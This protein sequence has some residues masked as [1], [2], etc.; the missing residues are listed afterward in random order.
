MYVLR[1][2]YYRWKRISNIVKLYLNNNDDKCNYI[3]NA[4]KIFISY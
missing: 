4:M 3:Y 1:L 2:K